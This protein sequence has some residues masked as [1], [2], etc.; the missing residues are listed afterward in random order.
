MQQQEAST[1]VA[2]APLPPAER[3][4]VALNAH[5]IEAQ[6]K[7]MIAAN[8]TIT[9]VIDKDGRTQAH[10]AAMVMRDVRTA[11]EKV[12]KSTRE[13]ANQFSAAVIAEEKRLSKL[14]QA[15]Q[16]RLT[17]LR[18][19]FD[20]KLAAEKAEKE[21]IE[22]A[23]IAAIRVKI[24]AIRNI[25]T[26][27][28]GATSAELL[29][30][31]MELEQFDT[32]ADFAELTDEA[33]S[34]LLSAM[35][36]L[37][38]LYYAAKA[39]EEEA[40]RQAQLAEENRLAALE[41]ERQRQEFAAQQAEAARI[42]AE[43]QAER[44]RLA[45]V[46]AARVAAETKRQ[47]EAQQAQIAAER[48]AQQEAQA[49]LDQ[50]Q[51]EFDEKI[52]AQAAEDARRKQVLADAAAAEQR[53]AE[54][55]TAQVV[56]AL[57]GEDGNEHLALLTEVIDG[58]A[59][60]IPG[61]YA[62]KSIAES[63]Q[64][65]KALGLVR[66]GALKTKDLSGERLAEWVARANGWKVAL[67]GDHDDAEMVCW[68]PNGIVQS[69]SVFGYRPDRNWSQ[70]GPILERLMMD[71]ITVTFEN[72]KFKPNVQ[73]KDFNEDGQPVL[74]FFECTSLLEAAM[75]AY[76]AVNFGSVLL[77]EAGA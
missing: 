41:I 38:D 20:Q 68:E 29:A 5:K 74:T 77:D 25:P 45:A 73:V 3:A 55:P 52:A 9:D 44:D 30:E 10:Q 19:K 50:A 72:G 39:R 37:N 71:G 70:G 34:A 75:F 76:V 7:E 62:S 12:A 2:I 33:N 59:A 21:R 66:A 69:F 60:P 43:Q 58:E 42:A 54:M 46:E 47:L 51:R 67:D 35:R 56:A 1:S 63:P 22:A 53:L 14:A 27:M 48:K 23:R 64:C 36:Q 13:D 24:E 61:P 8:S 32:S 16:D 4:I 11:L 26:G 65:V 18:D 40:A 49:R 17:A 15:E 28:A 31:K 6:L 57:E